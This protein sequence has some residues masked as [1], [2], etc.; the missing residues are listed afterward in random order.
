MK[1]RCLKI[2][3]LAL[4]FFPAAGL[5][6]ADMAANAADGF[7][8]HSL[9]FAEAADMVAA[10]SAD[11]RYAYGSQ[12][13]R[14]RAW[15]LGLR[16]YLPRLGLNISETDRLQQIGTDSFVKNYGINLDQ[17]LWDGGRT[18]ISRK[19][20][21]MELN[22]SHSRLG[23]MAADIAESA[24]AA[25]RNV[26]SSRAVLEIRETALRSLGEQRRILA[27][28][29]AL[30]LALP[31]DLAEADIALAEA[32]IEINALRSNLAEIERQFA[33][34]LGLDSLPVLRET[35]DIK[36]R[37][38]LPDIAAA[39]SLAEERNPELE[40]LRFS[41][42]K[43]EGEL[44]YASRSW[45]PTLR[46]A[47]GFALSGQ[48]YPL[49]RH[50]WS[51]GLSVD[52]SSPWFQNSF[53][54]HAGWEPPYDRTAQL[55]NSVSPLPDP[56]AGLGKKQAELAL[57]LEKEKYRAAFERAGRSARL[58]VE[59]CALA[60]QRRA[61]AVEAIALAAERCRVEEVRHSLGHIT[62]LELME[63]FMMYTQKEVA[64]VA[65][66]SALLEAERELE[67]LLNLRPGELA[68]YAA[69][70]DFVSAQSAGGES[71]SYSRSK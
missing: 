71:S 53:G 52:F 44:K 59:K 40:E 29:S 17:L 55:Q 51:V 58:A 65:A 15:L 47:G 39:I 46:L 33:E 69:G 62:R 14:E 56:A 13:L 20:E 50:T 49:T 24:L 32:G 23:R 64:A 3:L 1:G 42:H 25:Y 63:A 7:F 37:A 38:L 36:R 35:T 21:R 12:G 22:L 68:A 61:L 41:I 34:L 6:G 66:A 57:A 70:G 28:E 18:A 10:S 31:L 43:K 67:R 19:L 27:E 9:S 16:A 54:V 45:I 2:I 4:P 48:T 60:D 11:L 5:W 8:P 26:L 30:G